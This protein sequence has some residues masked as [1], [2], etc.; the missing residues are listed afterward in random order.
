M[1]SKCQLKHIWTKTKR[2]SKNW[3]KTQT[4]MIFQLQKSSFFCWFVKFR[5][6]E[7]IFEMKMKVTWVLEKKATH[8]YTHAFPPTIIWIYKGI[9]NKNR[10]FITRN[11]RKA[12]WKNSNKRIN[13]IQFLCKQNPQILTV[14]IYLP[15]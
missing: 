12:I 10:N 1:L 2:T 7:L 6:P 14:H 9:K 8:P 4:E 11:L 5:S 13:V 15:N 3:Q